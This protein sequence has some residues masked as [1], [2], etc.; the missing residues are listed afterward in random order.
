MIETIIIFDTGVEGRAPEKRSRVHR[1]A[2]GAARQVWNKGESEP[3]AIIARLLL[4][5]SRAS[6]GLFEKRIVTSS[7]NQEEL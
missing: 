5:G 2:G 6:L 4:L 1:N 3:G 7:V